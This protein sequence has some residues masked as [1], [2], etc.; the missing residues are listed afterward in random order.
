MLAFLAI[1]CAATGYHHP[2]NRHVTDQARLSG[3]HVYTMLK[4]EEAAH[5]VS[6]HIVRDRRAAEFDG[7]CQHGHQAG[8]QS[9]Q[10][11]AGES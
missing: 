4:L 6:V 2:P 8:M 1:V 10:L 11:G 5:S 3:P 7:S 9:I